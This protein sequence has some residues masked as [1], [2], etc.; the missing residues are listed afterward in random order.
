MIGVASL[1]CAATVAVFGE[2]CRKPAPPD[3]HLQLAYIECNIDDHHWSE[4]EAALRSFRASH[5]ESLDGALMEADLLIETHQLDDAKQLLDAILREHPKSVRAL[6]L[7]AELC[8][9]LDHWDEAEQWL[10][11]ATQE[12]P[13]DAETW[14]RL[15]DLYAAKHPAESVRCFQRA[16]KLA[17]ND[18][19]ALA[20]LATAY[21]EAGQFAEAKSAFASAMAMNRKVAHPNAVADYVYGHFLADQQDFKQAIR[22][23]D[24]S[25]SED[26]DYSDAYF[27]RA[28]ALIALNEWKPAASDLEHAA[29]DPKHELPSLA[30]MV[31]VYRELGDQDKAR[32]CAQRL[33]A[34]SQQRDR[35]RVAGNEIAGQMQWASGRMDQQKFS[36]AQQAYLR[37]VTSHPEAVR[38]WLQLGRC[39]MKLNRLPD[40]ESAFSKVIALD[41]SSSAA[42]VYLGQTLL[43]EKKPTAAQPEFIV[44][45]Q[46]EPMNIDGD[47][48]LAATYILE[49]QYGTAIQ[50]LKRAQRLAPSNQD[51]SLMLAEALYK[52]QQKEAAVLEVKRLLKSD[53][54]N[55]TARNMLAALGNH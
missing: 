43:M 45:R 11:K 48:G 53:P 20:G 19:L 51:V 28:E 50:I 1:L 23:Y 25:L 41:P 36:D 12:A 32:E 44:A 14:K 54:D 47:L 55:K 3:S 37:I 21:K 39:D 7:Y 24:L 15:G 34:E 29:S 30:L 38:A 17:P 5:P 13:D 35:E 31:R 46:I 9:K 42:H 22:Q 40:A 27:A 10:R 52:N 6:T 8:E 26:A 2:S 18:V 4:A 16:V 33:A 49:Q